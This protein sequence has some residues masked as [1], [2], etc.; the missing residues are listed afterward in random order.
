MI[1]IQELNKLNKGETS[2][3]RNL[4]KAVMQRIHAELP[5]EPFM[6][7]DGIVAAT[8]CADSGKLPIEGICTNLKTEYFAD[9][10]VPTESC[11]MHYQGNICQYGR[12]AC[13]A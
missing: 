4:W 8:V 13:S 3:A 5:Q 10:T 2:L 1:T 11:D 6:K 12:S 9:G 7:P